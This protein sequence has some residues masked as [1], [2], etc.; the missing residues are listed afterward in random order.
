MNVIAKGAGDSGE[1]L[2]GPKPAVEPHGDHLPR[3]ADSFGEF[4][5]IDFFE[6]TERPES[7]RGLT[8]HPLGPSDRHRDIPLR[9]SSFTSP[10]GR[11]GRESP[12]RGTSMSHRKETLQPLTTY[13]KAS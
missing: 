7:D 3:R 6:I 2:Q 10:C 11:D 4:R 13:V 12:S 8:N 9:S 5:L 1:S